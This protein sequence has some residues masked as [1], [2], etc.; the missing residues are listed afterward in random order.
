MT[1]FQHQS[2]PG[3]EKRSGIPDMQVALLPNLGLRTG[4]ISPQLPVFFFFFWGGGDWDINVRSILLQTP[5]TAVDT[6]EGCDYDFSFV[7]MLPQVDTPKE[8]LI[9]LASIFSSVNKFTLVKLF[10]ITI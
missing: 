9:P 6:F 2:S 4:K 1:P 10:G 7:S 3:N 5:E 8:K